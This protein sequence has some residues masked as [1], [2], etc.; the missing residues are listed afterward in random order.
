MGDAHYGVAK[1]DFAGRKVTLMADLDMGGAAGSDIDI[2][3]ITSSVDSSGVRFYKN[4]YDYPNWMPIGGEYLTDPDDCNTMIIAFFNGTFE[5]GGHHIDNLYCFRY[6]YPHPEISGYT[7][8][9]YA[10]GT[11]LFGVIGSLYDGEESPEILPSLRNFSLS[12]FVI[13]RRMVGG[14]VGCI[15]GGANAAAG[16]TISGGICIEN[17][18]NHTYVY[19][20]DSKGLGGIVGRSMGKGSIINC[21]NTGYM[22][23]AEYAAP[24]G[25]II[26]ANE[27]M[28]IYCCYNVGTIYTGTNTRGRGIGSDNTGSGY[29]V[30]DCY[31]LK[32]C[33]DDPEHPGYY[34]YNLADSVSVNVTELTEEKMK[35]G[36]LTELLNVN[37]TAYVTGEDGYPVLLWEAKADPGEG[38]ISV[39][40]PDGGTVT[41]AK[42][43]K[44]KNGTV[45]YL[46]DS[47]DTGYKFRYFT[48]NGAEL[49][50]NYI[51]VTGAC[52][53]SAFFEAVKP[54]TLRIIQ[55][56]IVDISVKKNGTVMNASGEAETVI[57]YPVAA[58]DS[59][60][61]GDV[62]IVSATIKEGKVPDDPDYVYSALVGAVKPYEYIFSY[63]QDDEV[64]GSDTTGEVTYEVDSMI[65]QEGITLALEVNPLKTYKLWKHIGDTSWYSE[66][67]SEFVITNARQL[68][69]LEVLVNSGTS[70][71]GKTVK[72]GNDISLA[73]DDGTEGSRYWD[74]IGTEN[75]PFAGTF[76]GQGYKITDMHGSANSLFAYVYGSESQT[77]SVKNVTVY[78]SYSGTNACGIASFTKYANI[79]NCSVYAD[80]TNI[81]PITGAG[82]G[83]IDKIG[84]IVGQAYKPTNITNCRNYGTLTIDASSVSA[85]YVGG[86]CA[87]LMSGSKISN[88]INK[89]N[90]IAE[91]AAGNYVGGLVGNLL[92]ELEQSA[93][94]G[95]VIASG[96]NIGG[97][98]GASTSKAAAIN[99]CYNV[100]DVTCPAGESDADCIGGI[101]G[102]ASFYV[103]KNSY[104]Y[105]KVTYVPKEGS[106]IITENIGAIIGKDGKKSTSSTDDTYTIDTANEYIDQS[107]TY[108]KLPDATY[109]AGMKTA[110][111][112]AFA[113][114][115]GVIKNINDDNVFVLGTNGYP[116]LKTVADAHVHSGGTAYCTETAICEICSVH[117]GKFDADNHKETEIS[118]KKLPVWNI[119]GYTGDEVCTECGKVVAS[120]ESVSADID[121]HALTV[122]VK[123]GESAAKEEVKEYSIKEFDLLKTTS[124]SVGYQ[125]GGTYG[126]QMVATEYVTLQSILADL[127]IDYAN[128]KSVIVTCSSSE[129]LITAESINEKKYHFEG[130]TATEVPFA[131]AI[132]YTS[133]DSAFE[134]LE[135]EAKMSD[136]LKLGYGI[137]KDQYING[138]GG[139]R[140]VSPVQSITL[141][142]E[143]H[144]HVYLKDGI[145]TH[146]CISCGAKEPSV[147]TGYE[148]A[149]CMSEGYSGDITY[150]CKAVV[151]GEKTSKKSHSFTT[152]V[153]NN[154]ATYT[155]DGTKT[156]KCDYG[157][158]TEDTVTAEG[159]KL[160]GITGINIDKS[161]AELATGDGLQLSATLLPE[162]AA[163]DIIWSSSDEGV[164]TVD[165]NG[166]V[167]AVGYGKAVI[168]ASAGK[169]SAKCEIQ[170]RFYDVTSALVKD[171]TITQGNYDRIYWAADNGIVKGARDASGTIFFNTKGETTRAQ[172]AVMLYRLAKLIDPQAAA[173]ALQKGKESTRFTDLA[174]VSQG[175]VEGIYWAVGAG[176]TV[177]YTE[178]NGTQTY[179]PNNSISRASTIIMMYRMAGKPQV[180]LTSTGFKDVDGVIDKSRDTYK[181][182]AWAKAKGITA[183]VK[184]SSNTYIFDTQSNI[185]RQQMVT[186]IYR[187]YYSR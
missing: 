141:T 52:D 110:D 183:G 64:K 147:L 32:G 123:N 45:V 180:T 37:G 65:A 11:G 171:G 87:H 68:A 13:G 25:G 167:T 170:T 84:G 148:E 105:G 121:R 41:S 15:G 40:K 158:G 74:G 186:F 1:H 137:T 133:G 10:Q 71:A 48:N 86:I 9:G 47:E 115:S 77:A 72:L 20:T 5:G 46:Y 80:I 53:I 101:V 138:A 31:Y 134:L 124:P 153:Y 93:N 103:I 126:S 85:A 109:T 59:L 43:G 58:G 81:N 113:S 56:E 119:D 129:D 90:V 89:G 34:D 22:W 88:C 23:Y 140:L 60:Y 50:G 114:A 172:M 98:A 92:G 63:M 78:G 7:A 156:A 163:G 112:S 164:A 128:V 106:E 175:A 107:L 174:G 35:D 67:K 30:S 127:D 111:A 12:G 161:S 54:G 173:K 16:T 125:Y 185:Q 160:K 187:Y 142:I 79:E 8:F 166:K 82:T 24:A 157:C 154:D 38:S 131:F 108:D 57:G 19:G 39:Q 99:A 144:E 70:F 28:D 69:G 130:D 168:T 159:T 118:G 102:F 162:G 181:A 62:L 21:Y 151:K 178:S 152:Y 95:D 2:E 51:T 76:D 4:G 179:R 169:Y 66:S 73:N 3:T 17:I 94:Y 14:V 55:S 117:Y 100:G 91:T 139:R 83:N 120:G 149:T 132:K 150:E 122:Y 182:I 135:A 6:S 33:A 96:R 61:E 29:T 176:I 145:C 26:G 165:T 36:T 116:E 146:A 49:T 155:S 104:N 27:E 177:G 97:I 44:I 184:Q 75:K 136:Y 42:T 143:E 18:A